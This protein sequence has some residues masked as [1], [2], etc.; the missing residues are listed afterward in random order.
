MRHAGGGWQAFSGNQE[1][2]HRNLRLISYGSGFLPCRGE[3]ADRMGC[4][5]LCLWWLGLCRIP[6]LRIETWGTRR[7]ALLKDRK[8]S[9]NNGKGNGKG[10]RRS[11]DCVWR[12][13]PRQTSL[14]MTTPLGLH[15][16]PP[17]SGFPSG[18]TER[19]ARATAEGKDKS[20]CKSKCCMSG[21][22]ASHPF[23]DEAVKWM[24]HP[25][26][27]RDRKKAKAKAGTLQLRGWFLSSWRRW[28]H[29]T[30]RHGIGGRTAPPYWLPWWCWRGC[31]GRA[32]RTWWGRRLPACRTSIR[33]GR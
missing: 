28:L 32:G 22:V 25:S 5:C 26:L 15:A 11:F 7:P 33:A 2:F 24:G 12:I 4:F 8:T 16:R 20:K 18:R 3:K 21:C 30:P 13:R 19:K 31:R 17:N 14:R 6:G 1:V 29:W 10:N 9:K 23:H 27:L